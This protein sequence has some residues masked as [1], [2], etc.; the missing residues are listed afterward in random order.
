MSFLFRSLGICVGFPYL[1]LNI[2][3]VG[4]FI[5]NDDILRLAIDVRNKTKRQFSIRQF[6][7]ECCILM[8]HPSLI[9]RIWSRTKWT[10]IYVWY[11]YETDALLVSNFVTCQ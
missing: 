5:S 4:Q 7:I 2:R 8:M 1:V 9:S 6:R 3:L 11:E 10:F